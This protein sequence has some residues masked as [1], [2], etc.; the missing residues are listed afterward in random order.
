MNNLFFVVK[1]KNI[2]SIR[3]ALIADYPNLSC[4]LHY[5][6]FGTVFAFTLIQFK[7]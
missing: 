7:N 5:P 6:H 2:Y 3:F 4:D 1:Y